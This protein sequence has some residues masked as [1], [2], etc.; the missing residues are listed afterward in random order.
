MAQVLGLITTRGKA[1]MVKHGVELSRSTRNVS[2]IINFNKIY[3]NLTLV[4]QVPSAYSAICVN[5]RKKHISNYPLNNS[6]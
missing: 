6:G 5:L 4:S 2:R 3:G 1:T